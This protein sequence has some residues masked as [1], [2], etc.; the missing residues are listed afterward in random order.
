MLKIERNDVLKD[1]DTKDHHQVQKD[2]D[3]RR[4]QKDKDIKDR[5]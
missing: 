4:V 3:P 2:K 5:R 1:N